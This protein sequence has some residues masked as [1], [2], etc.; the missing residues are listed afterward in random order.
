CKFFLDFPEKMAEVDKNT[1]SKY[2]KILASLDANKEIDIQSLYAESKTEIRK[3][4]DYWLD[5][6]RRNDV[7]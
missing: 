5:F 2:K 7:M 3:Q 6:S 4:I 1:R